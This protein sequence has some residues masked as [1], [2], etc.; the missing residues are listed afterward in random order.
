MSRIPEFK[1]THIYL[2]GPGLRILVKNDI[3]DMD[4]DEWFDAHPSISDKINS[5]LIKSMFGE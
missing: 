3:P 5:F 4:W 2:V 1:H